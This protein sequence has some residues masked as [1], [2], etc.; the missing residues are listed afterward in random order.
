MYILAT[1]PCIMPITTA[2]HIETVV[3]SAGYLEHTG[4]V[5]HLSALWIVAQKDFAVA[6]TDI[7]KVIHIRV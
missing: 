6:L 3:H 2:P 7:A 5:I 1:C 4:L